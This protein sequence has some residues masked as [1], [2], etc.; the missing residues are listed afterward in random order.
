MGIATDD[1]GTAALCSCFSVFEHHHVVEQCS[2]RISPIPDMLFSTLALWRLRP[3]CGDSSSCSRSPCLE[4]KTEPMTNALPPHTRTL[5]YHTYPYLPT[6]PHH[7]LR[8][9]PSHCHWSLSASPTRMPDLAGK[10]DARTRTRSLG[11]LRL[12]LTSTAAR[13][14]TKP[15]LT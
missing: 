14:P 3:S 6:F 15:D 9:T 11:N 1:Y 2:S 4:I 8:G 5:S 12:G 13:S 7:A 10:P